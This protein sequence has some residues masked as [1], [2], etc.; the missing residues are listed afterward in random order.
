MPE[1]RDRDP[2]APQIL[3]LEDDIMLR[4]AMAVALQRHGLVVHAMGSAE[5]ARRVLGNDAT[6]VGIIMEIGLGD[7]G[8]FLTDIKKA[9]PEMAI[10]VLTGRPDLLL[11]QAT[12]PREAH[13]L[14]PCPMR[15][16]V[17]TMRGLIVRQCAVAPGLRD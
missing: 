15:R 13:L 4:A 11:G 9:W 17:T 10:V 2:A 14:K 3:L 1:G 6:I 12:G 8:A 5:Q 7:A 16:V